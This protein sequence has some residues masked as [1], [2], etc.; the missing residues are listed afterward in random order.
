MYYNEASEYF[1]KVLKSEKIELTVSFKKNLLGVMSEMCG[2]SEEDHKIR[3][4]IIIGVNIEL[5]FQTISPKSYF[6]MYKDNLEGEKLARFFKSLALFCDNGWYIV[7]SVNDNYIEYGIFR[8]YTGIDGETFEDYFKTNYYPEDCHMIMLNAISNFDIMIVRHDED[9]AIISQRFIA[10]NSDEKEYYEVFKEL[11]KD[12]VE[13]CEIDNRVFFRNCFLK[14][15]RNLPLRIHGTIMLVVDNDYVV[16]E[17]V[18]SG[19]KIEP[20]I[21]FAKVFRENKTI[22]SYADSENVYSLV[23][24]LYEMLNTDGITI[25]TNKARI[26]HYN[27]FYQGEIPKDI[28]GGARKRTALGI[29]ENLD[30]HGVKGVYFQS[31]DG[32]VFYKRK[33]V[34][35]D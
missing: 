35:D 28:R 5:I 10:P 19:I 21:D 4:Q 15:L 26:T 3:P 25:I 12:I 30:L 8:R 2:Y 9:D 24:V 33:G 31:Q 16:P 1:D 34:E 7:I 20:T 6:I 14:L 23:G 32:A 29:L 27:M 17:T 13:K 11:S 18:L 22:Q